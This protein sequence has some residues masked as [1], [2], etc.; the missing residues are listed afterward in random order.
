MTRNVFLGLLSILLLATGAG[1]AKKPRKA[2]KAAVQQSSQGFDLYGRKQYRDAIR[3]WEEAYRL[4]PQPKTLY[5]IASAQRKDGQTAAAIETYRRYLKEDPESELK[6]EVERQLVELPAKLKEEQGDGLLAAREYDK[7]VEALQAAYKLRPGPGLLFKI[8]TA[9]RLAGSAPEAIAAYELAL[10]GELLPAQKLEAEK[11]LGELRSQ[12][13]EARARKLMERGEFAQA[14]EAFDAAYRQRPQNGLRLGLAQAE[15]RAGRLRDARKDFERFLQDEPQTP[16][17]A[18]VDGFIAQVQALLEDERAQKLYGGAQYEPAAKAW[19]AAY[20]IRPMPVFLFQLGRARRQ[21][22]RS[23][24]ALAAFERFLK[25][26]EAGRTGLMLEAQ[27]NVRELKDLLA[28]RREAEES[29]RPPPIYKR[30]W[31]WGV[32]AGVAAGAGAGVGTAIGLSSRDTRD[33]ST[34]L[35]FERLK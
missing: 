18:E 5:N 27:G 34:D 33:L 35:G 25:D 8:A 21:A 2:G 6:G 22:G 24:E 29:R 26:P 1:A 30:A 31:F 19:E 23:R 10:Q 13:E 17:R 12:K 28:S 14:A 15:L 20:Q 11:Y 4:D 9:R 7:A 16:L 3:A 32:I